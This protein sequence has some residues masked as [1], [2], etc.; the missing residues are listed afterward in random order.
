MPFDQSTI[1]DVTDGL[2]GGD[3][4]IAW[5]SSAPTGTW[6]HVYLDRV[7]VWSGTARSCV[8]PYPGNAVRID[9]GAVLATEAWLDLSSELPSAPDDRVTLTWTGGTFLDTAIAG[10]EVFQSD[11]PGLAVDYSAPV[12]TIAAYSAGQITDGWSQGGWNDGGW[13]ESAGY[14]SW[15][16]DH[17]AGGVWSFGVK[18]LDQFGNLA[19]TLE[20][21]ATVI[22]AP[23]PPAR[24]A[25]GRRLTYIYNATP[26]TVTLN[27]LAPNGS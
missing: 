10:F 4:A 14:Y 24:N 17:L 20:T 3:L 19:H 25:S 6:F 16:S 22:A 23:P 21:T 5:D 18:T 12:A 1:H 27:W 26:H 15:T 9:V 7:R 2:R 11:G 13:G 8:L